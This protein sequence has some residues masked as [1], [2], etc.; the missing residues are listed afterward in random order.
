MTKTRDELL[1][2]PKVRIHV[3]L[4]IVNLNDLGGKCRTD[5]QHEYH[6]MA[7]RLYQM[8]MSWRERTR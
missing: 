5:R 7:R 2:N 4:R 8:L 3:A 1:E 6:T